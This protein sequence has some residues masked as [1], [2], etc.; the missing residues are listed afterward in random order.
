[1]KP[2]HNKA[3]VIGG[4]GFIGS[5]LVR[6]LIKAGYDVIVVD[7]L[8]SRA[9][10]NL[11]PMAKFFKLDISNPKLFNIFKKEG[12]NI[13]YHLGGPINLRRKIDDPLFDNALNIFASFRK[14]LNFCYIS[15]IQK[16]IFISSGGAIYSEAQY[17]PSR[18]NHV[19][20]PSSLYGLANFFLEK[21][22]EEYSK[23]HKLN[24]I[25]LRLSNVY[26]PK[27]WES[28]IIPSLIKHAL[29]SAP[30][31][32]NGDGEQTRDFLYIEDAVRALLVAAKTKKGGIYNVASGQEISLNQLFRK[33]TEILNIKL[34]PQ[35][36]FNEELGPRRS[37]L[38]ISKIK[39]ELRWRPKINL[40]KG[41]EKTVN[42]FKNN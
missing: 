35:Y 7:H 31:I 5:H 21:L 27:Q 10:Q 15:N 39:K 19:P 23:I 12:P 36:R 3:M 14:I 28:G 33:I 2:L 30:P 16:F 13:V 20:C 6:A 17:T 25:I 41:L 11:D 42:W 9:K 18:E 32:I 8:R 29:K 40:K 22:L 37:V 34:K 38:N 1:M 4:A 26:G 24:Y